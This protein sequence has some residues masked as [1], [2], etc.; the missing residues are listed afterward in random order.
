MPAVAGRADE[1]TAGASLDPEEILRLVR[2]VSTSLDSAFHGEDHWR[3]VASIG[4]ELAPSTSACDAIVVVLF[5]VLHD[6]HRIGDDD[7]PLHGA[8]GAA[9]VRSLD[10]ERLGFA[11]S[12]LALVADA[13][14]GHTGG[15]VSGDP[16]IGTCWDADRLTLRRV[17]VEPA[18]RYMS[19]AAGKEAAA[20]RRRFVPVTDWSEITRRVRE[21]SRPAPSIRPQRT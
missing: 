21:L 12:Q 3:D 9:L 16:T 13:C 6:A 5:A 19:T 1:M 18:V 20:A 8:R 17:G 2:P 7:D 4:L 10:L 14:R 11:E 15:A